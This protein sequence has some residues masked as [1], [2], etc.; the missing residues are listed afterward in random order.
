M[1]DQPMPSLTDTQ[2]GF[3][4]ALLSTLAARYTWSPS[5]ATIFTSELPS[6]FST[7]LP[8]GGT[9]TPVPGHPAHAMHHPAAHGVNPL[10]VAATRHANQQMQ[11]A[12]SLQ[13]PGVPDPSLQHHQ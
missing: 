9:N 10:L 11:V 12:Q 4:P 6:N 1:P 13:V 7:P 5:T 8:T 3:T 2:A